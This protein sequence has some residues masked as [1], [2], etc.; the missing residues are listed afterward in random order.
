MKTYHLEFY[1]LKYILFVLMLMMSSSLAH[2]K[3]YPV[4]SNMHDWFMTLKSGFGPC[5]ADADGNV[6]QDNDWS[7]V[8]DPSKP[9]IHYKVFLDKEW[10]DVPDEAVI[11]QPNLYG[12]TMVWPGPLVYGYGG[13][14]PQ[15][16]RCF[17]P[18]S[19]G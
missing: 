4:G 11:N 18:G 2:D 17:M 15:R 12:Q 3:R 1:P 6:L 8:N 9:N 19:M 5:C 7:S 16:I 13:T 14:N 10:I